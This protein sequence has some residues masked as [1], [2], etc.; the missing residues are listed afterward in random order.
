MCLALPGKIIERRDGPGGLPFARVEF[1]TV[2]REVCLAYTPDAACG[3][4]VVVHVGF[5]IQHLDEAAARRTLDL[6]D[7]GVTG[8]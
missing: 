8:E 1:G 6:L 7:D 2:V 5:A 4:Y 3:D